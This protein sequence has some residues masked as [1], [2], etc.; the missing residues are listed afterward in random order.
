MAELVVRDLE[1]DVK[2]RLIRLARKHGHS[3]E[4]EVREILRRAARD[5]ARPAPRLG[6]TIAARFRGL[7]LEQDLPELRGSVRHFS[8]PSI[9]VVDPWNAK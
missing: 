4:E 6:S 2:S 3:L 5:S 9:T 8:D 7:G 1:E